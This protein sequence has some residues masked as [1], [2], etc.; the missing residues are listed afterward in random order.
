[1]KK[2]QLALLI[3]STL[4]LI[5]CGG[6]TERPKSAEQLKIELEVQENDNPLKY[7]SLE[8]LEMKT[9]SKKVKNG[10]L[11]RDAEY[12]QDGV[13]LKG[14]VKNNAT[15][16]DYKDITIRVVYLSKTESIIKEANY[17]IYDFFRHGTSTAFSVNTRAED[18]PTFFE[19]FNVTIENAEVVY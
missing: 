6:N 19:S 3:I 11:F 15:V 10:G 5:N 13:A 2:K 17:T 14:S 1:M 12:A 8:N 7:L 9:L 18:T 16:S 4:L